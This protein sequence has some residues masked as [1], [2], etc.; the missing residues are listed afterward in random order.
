MA[1]LVSD[2]TSDY[3]LAATAQGLAEW[4]EHLITEIHGDES[5]SDT[6]R[7]AII[8]ARR[9]QGKFKNNVMQI[10]SCCRITKVDRVEHLRAS[11]IKP[12][13]DCKSADERI[14]ATNGLLL[15]PTIDHLFDRGFISF[16]NNGRL[17][18]S[19]AAHFPSLEKMGIHTNSTLSVGA[20]CE[21]QKTFLDYHREEVFLAAR[22]SQNLY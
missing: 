22:L 16:E 14:A 5:L 10:E 7:E 13:R 2:F 3:K 18:I 6:E 20:F 8:L 9:G 15:T 19:P 1:Y 17:L 12:W 11:H 21:E 4:E